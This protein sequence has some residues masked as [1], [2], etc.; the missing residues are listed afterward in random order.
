MHHSDDRIPLKP[1]WEKNAH[2]NQAKYKDLY[3]QSIQDPEGFWAKQAERITWTKKWDKVKDTSFIK[4]VHVKWYEGGKLNASY[5]CIDRHLEK[6]AD[7]VAFYWE[8]DSTTEETIT[9]TYRQLH[10]KVCRLANVL[11]ANGVKKGDRVTIYMP[12]IP[13]AVYSMLACARIG[14]IHSVVFGGFSP[15]SLATRIQDCDSGFLITADEGY[16]G[17]K[18]VPLKVNADEAAKKCPGLRKMLVVQR[19]KAK[20]DWDASRDI[21]YHEAVTQVS[22][23]CEPEVMDAED[24]LYILYTSGSTGKPKGVMHTTGGYMVYTALT[25][26]VVFDYKPEDVYW[27]AADVGW[28]TGHSYIVYGPLANCATSV[29]FEGVP[30][31]PTASRIW[32]VIDEYKVNILYTAPTLIRTLMREGEE[33]VKKT[34]RKSLRLLGSVG[35]PINPEAWKWYF[36]VAGDSRSPIVDTWWQT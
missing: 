1:E 30:T 19:T 35:E 26:E 7:R 24:P 13:E 29:L 36:E 11:K 6:H 27:C 12:M 14:A 20:V 3:Q 4:P 31:W 10:E 5:N 33:F 23:Q 2:V 34:S 32:E 28:V 15:D 17:G 9:I 16:R 8:P 25:H 21:W 22:D 18:T